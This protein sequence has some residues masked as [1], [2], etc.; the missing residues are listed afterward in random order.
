MTTYAQV[1]E[2]LGARGK[3]FSLA[4]RISLRRY[5][6]E[7]GDRHCGLCGA[8]GGIC[9][10]GVEVPTV[11]RSLTYLEGYR[12]A[13]LARSTYR[14]LPAGRNASACGDCGRCLVACRLALPVRRLA[15]EAHARLSG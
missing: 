11:L 13:E 7:I 8:C 3:R 14:S 1:E 12:E 10:R 6:L 4:D 5:A 2:N 15:R 9:P